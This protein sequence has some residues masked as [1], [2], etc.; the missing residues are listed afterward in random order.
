M[1]LNGKRFGDILLQENI[2]S[3]TQLD[4]ALAFQ[5]KNT[6][7]KLGDVLIHLDFAGESA[8]LKAATLDYHIPMAIELLK[9]MGRNT[10]HLSHLGLTENGISLHDDNHNLDQDEDLLDQFRY[11]FKIPKINDAL[12]STFDVNE[13]NVINTLLTF[14]NRS[15]YQQAIKYALNS[16]GDFAN[17]NLIIY[18]LTWLYTKEE[19]Y[20]DAYA[21]NRQMNTLYMDQSYTL[22]LLAFGKLQQK[23][24]IGAISIYKSL[25]KFP[26]SKVNLIWFFYFAY[27]FDLNGDNKILAEK[28]YT[29]YKKNNQNIDFLQTFVDDRLNIFHKK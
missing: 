24:C 15:K 5:S 23:D 18:L 26:E 2:I 9:K 12:L 21:M 10:D 22:E 4:K 29:Y 3:K 28:F 20:D 11:K 1:L 14:I 17:P 27:A 7:M 8:I 6:H 16:I 25:L 13:E 19:L